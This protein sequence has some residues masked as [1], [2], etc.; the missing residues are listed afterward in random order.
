MPQVEVGVDSVAS[1]QVGEF[2][3]RV[4]P[5]RGQVLIPVGV[6]VGP[7]DHRKRGA[8]LSVARTR[9]PD[10]PPLPAVFDEVVFDLG[11]KLYGSLGIARDDTGGRRKAR[12]RNYR[13]YDAPLAGIVC[14]NREDWA[15]ASR[16]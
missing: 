14:M 15:V 16:W 8:A 6:G 9:E 4:L 7:A 10:I 13:F 1:R 12:L 5:P 3:D 2:P 11:V